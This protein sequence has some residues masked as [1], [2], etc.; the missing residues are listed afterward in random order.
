M[1]FA[2]RLK[3][4]MA[5]IFD[6]SSLYELWYCH[7]PPSMKPI[8]FA[9][10]FAHTVRKIETNSVNN[11]CFI[12][13]MLTRACT[14]RFVANAVG[15]RYAIYTQSWIQWRKI[16]IPGVWV[17]LLGLVHFYFSFYSNNLSNY[18]KK[19]TLICLENRWRF[20]S[21]ELKIDVL[22]GTSFYK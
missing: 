19:F 4:Q 6:P 11:W 16:H 22:E 1:P 13:T 17:R 3:A 15:G 5:P 18:S 2:L 8:I 21:I 9:L 20:V 7:G 12:N 14:F 10:F